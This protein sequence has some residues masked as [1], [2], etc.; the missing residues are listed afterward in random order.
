VAKNGTDSCRVCA[1]C[2]HY[3]IDGDSGENT[4]LH[5]DGLMYIDDELEEV[6]DAWES[7]SD[8]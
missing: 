7:E 8:E 2:R 6:C 1:F 5:P 4:C 3:E